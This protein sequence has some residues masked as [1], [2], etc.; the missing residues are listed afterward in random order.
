MQRYVVVQE[1]EESWCVRHDGADLYRYPTQDEAQGAALALANDAMQRG[2]AAT[3]VILPGKP[4]LSVKVERTDKAR[5]YS[6]M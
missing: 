6:G 5:R 3:V 4:D 2:A 1:H